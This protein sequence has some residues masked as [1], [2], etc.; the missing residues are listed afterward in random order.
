[1]P[2]WILI[3][4][5]EFEFT[6]VNMKLPQ[7]I[8]ICR[9]ELEIAA[10]NL[11]LQLW[12]WI[13]HGAFEFAV[14]NLDLSWRIWICCGEFEFAT[15]DLPW[16]ILICCG[17][18]K[19]A[20]VNLNFPWRILIY[21]G[22]YEI[23]AV[24]LNLQLW[25]WICHGEFEIYGDPQVSRQNFK[26]FPQYFIVRSKIFNYLL[27]HCKTFFLA[28]KLSSS[29]QNFLTKAKLP[30]QGKTSSPRQNFLTKAKLPH[31]GK[32]LLF[33]WQT[34]KSKA[35]LSLRWQNFF[36]T[37]KLF[38]QSVYNLRGG[39]RLFYRSYFFR[40]LPV[41]GRSFQPFCELKVPFQVSLQSRSQSFI[42]LL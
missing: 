4:Y 33:S 22:E 23:A 32:K 8:W 24:N 35:N 5:G 25:I 42:C 38:I 16:W 21:Y 7:W 10:V 15:V 18:F 3:C 34:F 36:T 6:V 37:A 41:L 28:A 17:E 30:H 40:S 11:N 9:V 2:L 39:V 31:Q 27:N 13:C 19:F 29:R 20:V 14:V 1:M 12:I 26:F